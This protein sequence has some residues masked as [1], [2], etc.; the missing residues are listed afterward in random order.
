MRA[1]ITL[2][3]ITLLIVALSLSSCKQRPASGPATA[4]IATAG[5]A[6]ALV[7]G[8]KQVSRVGATLDQPVVVQVNDA[9]G[10]AVPNAM[11]ILSGTPGEAFDPP[12]GLT[13]SSGQL[14]T[15]VSA[16]GMAGHF[17]VIAAVNGGK[18]PLTVDEIALG[19]EETLGR[20]VATQHCARCHDPESTP[21]RVSNMDNLNPKPHPFTEGDTFNK[22]SDADL[23]SVISHGGP[24]LNKSAEMP[25]FGYTF[26]KT[27]IQALVSY[28]RAVSDPPYNAPAGAYASK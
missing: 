17:Q 21:E 4:G 22:I 26:G 27:E 13:D 7:S 18:A 28:I 9:Q 23:I 15:Q 12:G 6:V 8:D 20:Q 14:S 24:A 25:P 1:R 2:L 16:P 19:Y 3:R 10:T 5:D 11:V